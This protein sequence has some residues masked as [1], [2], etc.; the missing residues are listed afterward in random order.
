MIS[1]LA[2]RAIVPG[3]FAIAGLALMPSP[4]AAQAAPKQEKLS[5]GIEA[6]Q[7]PKYARITVTGKRFTPGG[8]VFVTGTPA[9]GTSEP[10]D[11]GRLLADDKGALKV[12]KDLQCTTTLQDEATRPV[13]FT[14]TDSVS[15]RTAKQRVDGSAW[16][17][18]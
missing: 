6:E 8:V 15:G 14:V 17:C 12:V 1:S 11:L 18:R 5:V 3:V 13:M 16:W 10:I 2:R 9:P 7:V 4:S